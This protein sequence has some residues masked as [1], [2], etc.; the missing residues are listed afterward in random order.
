[1]YCTYLTIYSGDKLPPY[2]IGS[3]SIKKYNEGYCGSVTSKKY[4]SI[5]NEELKSNRHLFDTIILTEH[6]TRTEALAQELAYQKAKDVVRNPDFINMAI[7]APNGCFGMDVSGDLNVWYNN[8]IWKGRK[9]TEDHRTKRALAITGDKNGMFGKTHSEES[10][11]KISNASKGTN[12]PMHHSHGRTPPG[13]GRNDEKHPQFGKHWYHNPITGE[14]VCCFENEKPSGFI[15][16]RSMKNFG[17]HREV[18]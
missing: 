4:K 2:Y 10:L 8:P 15:L 5:W 1:M 6:E 13:L 16:G 12:N 9:Q 11:Q 14:S 17:K 18:K 3:T 7:A